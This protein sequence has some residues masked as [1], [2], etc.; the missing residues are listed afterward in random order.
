MT[1]NELKEIVDERIKTRQESLPV[2]AFYISSQLNI[3]LKNSIEAKEDFGN[4]NLFKS[5][6]AVYTL[7]KG[8]YIIYFNEHYAYKN[9]SIAHEIAH[10]ILGHTSEGVEQHH[11]AQLMASIMVAPI[12]LIHKYKIKSASELSEICKMPIEAA[13]AYWHEITQ[14]K[15]RFHFFYKNKYTKIGSIIGLLLVT[16]VLFCWYHTK[17]NATITYIKPSEILTYSTEIPSVTPSYPPTDE[18]NI[19]T[20][21]VTPSGEKYHRAI[22][23]H[24]KNAENIIEFSIENA[25]KAG[26]DPCKDCIGE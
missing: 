21:Y 20:V 19:Q 26:F 23:R 1:Y 24:I 22:C 14:R 12:D 15:E 2:D 16:T 9:F 7:N 8:E 4:E 3:R 25:K 6:N 5:S 10:H 17:N 18:T 11:D 13:E